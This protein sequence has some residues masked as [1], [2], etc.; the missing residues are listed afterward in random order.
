MTLPGMMPPRTRRTTRA[1]RTT[2]IAR[3]TRGFGR[4]EPNVTAL[5]LPALCL[6]CLLVVRCGDDEPTATDPPKAE[7]RISTSTLEFD[8]VTVGQSVELSVSITNAGGGTLAG[9]LFE[10]CSEFSIVSGG[11]YSLDS[12]Q[13]QEFQVRYTPSAL[14]RAVCSLRAGNQFCT[15]IECSGVGADRPPLCRWSLERALFDSVEVGNAR[16]LTVELS[17]AGGGILAGIVTP[18]CE[19]FSVRAGAAY[20][21]AAGESH[22]VTIRFSPQTTGAYSCALET[23]GPGCGGLSLEGVGVAWQPVCSLSGEALDFGVVPIGQSVDRELTLTNSG[24]GLLT[25][26]W[27][28]TCSDFRILGESAF[29]LRAGEDQVIRVRF[30]PASAGMAAC[31]L[32]TADLSC[33]EVA[34]SGSGLDSTPRCRLS[35]PLLDFPGVVLGDTAGVSFEITN[36]GGGTLTGAFSPSC[37]DF[38][39]VGESEY[40]LAVG[41]SLSVVAGGTYTLSPG[42]R[43]VV[44]VRFRP[45]TTSLVECTLE[46]GQDLCANV[47]CSG[48]GLNLGACCTNATCTIRLRTECDAAGGIYMGDLILCHPGLC[49]SDRVVPLPR[50]AP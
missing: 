13:T 39:V 3:R 40:V 29:S 50:P 36:S 10:S 2:R 8:T 20:S 16:D 43:Q 42:Q 19:E 28:L 25:G 48:R 44:T 12:G 46:I 27:D 5:L 45:S 41:E 23:D 33:A 4:R 21:I 32:R 17:N 7:C 37:P 14:G 6:L 31:T 49:A 1:S 24:S 9:T 22:S 30:H 15:V 26:R 11:S 34:L 18:S 38:S 35:D 47:P